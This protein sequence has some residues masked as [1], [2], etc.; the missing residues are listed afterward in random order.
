MCTSVFSSRFSQYHISN[1]FQ[2]FLIFHYLYK[3]SVTCEKTNI[4]GLLFED[5]FTLVFS[6]SDL[7]GLISPWTS[8]IWKTT[9]MEMFILK[10]THQEDN[11]TY[12]VKITE[13]YT[14]WKDYW[15]TLQYYF[16]KQ[17]KLSQ[18]SHDKFRPSTGFRSAKILQYHPSSTLYI[19]VTQFIY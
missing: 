9:A 14:N 18:I 2:I 13:V 6:P 19:H 8:L 7:R 11:R 5:S 3:V 10:D 12:S 16:V 4:P 15:S 17:F 1:I